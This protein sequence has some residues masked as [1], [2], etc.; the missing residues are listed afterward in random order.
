MGATEKPAAPSTCA[1]ERAGPSGSSRCLPIA[2]HTPALP[3][4]EESPDSTRLVKRALWA[5]FVLVVPPVGFEPTCPKTL[6]WQRSAS[7]ASATGGAPC[8]S[9][10]ESGDRQ[11]PFSSPNGFCQDQLRVCVNHRCN[12]IRSTDSKLVRPRTERT[13]PRQASPS[14]LPLDHPCRGQ[15]EE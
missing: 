15:L 12:H 5:R 13:L 4:E 11:L 1:W 3:T 10:L 7:T 6:R 9:P 8:L 14:L 2:R